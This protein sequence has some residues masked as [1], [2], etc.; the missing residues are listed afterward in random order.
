MSGL[1]GASMGNL[2]TRVRSDGNS[3]NATLDVYARQIRL[4]RNDG[5]R[6]S[7]RPNAHKWSHIG[8]GGNRLVN[9]L[10][11]PNIVSVQT[12]TT[13]PAGLSASDANATWTRSDNNDV[14]II[15]GHCL[16]LAFSI[17]FVDGE[18]DLIQSTDG[19]GLPPAPISLRNGVEPSALAPGVS[20][21]PW[22]AGGQDGFEIQ[23]APLTFGMNANAL[24]DS[25]AANNVSTRRRVVSRTPFGTAIAP[26]SQYILIQN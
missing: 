18:G 15:R 10:V 13:L 5:V 16:D 22:P 6:S 11:T 8:V 17:E 19:Y 21:L 9:Q 26:P 1:Y 25:I 4:F 12:D 14:L 7:H 24:F 3:T 20:V 23:I 2:N